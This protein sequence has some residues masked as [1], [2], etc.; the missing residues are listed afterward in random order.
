MRSITDVESAKQTAQSYLDSKYLRAD[1]NY[2]PTSKQ[3]T[4]D[5]LMYQKY[6]ELIGYLRSTVKNRELFDFLTSQ[7]A[8]STILHHDAG[9]DFVFPI[10]VFPVPLLSYT[11][12]KLF[13]A[14]QTKGSQYPDNKKNDFLDITSERFLAVIAKETSFVIDE[15]LGD[16]DVLDLGLKT[17]VSTPE[18]YGD[19]PKRPISEA[20]TAQSK[21]ALPD[22]SDDD[23]I[24]P[25]DSDQKMS[26]KSESVKLDANTTETMRSTEISSTKLS[27]RI[28][29]SEI[30]I[31]ETLIH[32]EHPIK[33]Y[34]RER[35]INLL[36][37]NELPQLWSELTPMTISDATNR[38]KPY[39]VT[40]WQVEDNDL[41][42]S[43]DDRSDS[44]K[45]ILLRHETMNQLFLVKILSSF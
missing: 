23:G 13:K 45:Y 40:P 41:V 39:M 38:F 27:D 3:I 26:E 42:I 14:K 15:Q 33:E 20:P 37:L 31:I 35:I 32:S 19:V 28:S 36:K 21:A 5:S 25:I 18:S 6:A 9:S 34:L 43:A 10:K 12:S 1:W 2:I 44:D 11:R 30:R 29:S 17:S 16:D 8:Y 22:I 7:F 24:S 4:Q